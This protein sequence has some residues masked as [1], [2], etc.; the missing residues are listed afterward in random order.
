MPADWYRKDVEESLRGEI[1]IELAG[2]VLR[3]RKEDLEAGTYRIGMLCT[4]QVSGKREFAWSDKE[5]TIP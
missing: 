1:H 4:N 5:I 2:F 3:L